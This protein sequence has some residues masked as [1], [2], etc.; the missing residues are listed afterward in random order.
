MMRAA[1]AARRVLRGFSKPLLAVVAVLAA[2]L[3]AEGL[4]RLI[5]LRGEYGQLVPLGDV[6]TRTVDGV[7]LWAEKY[8]RYDNDDI[9]AAREDRNAF[10]IIGLGDSIMYGVQ[11]PKEGTYLEQMRSLVAVARR[12]PFGSSTWRSPASTPCKRTPPTK[13]SR[14]R[15]SPISSWCTIGSTMRDS[16]GWSAATWWISPIFQ[17]TAA[18]WCGPCRFLRT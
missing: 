12:G 11:Q 15:S 7:V 14:T 13:R 8:P 18:W 4:A 2:I 16:I 6:P 10:T 9:E 1:V 3:V 17:P 5:G